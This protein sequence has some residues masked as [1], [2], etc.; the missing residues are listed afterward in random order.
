MFLLDRVLC[1][2]CWSDSDGCVVAVMVMLMVK[3]LIKVMMVVKSLNHVEGTFTTVA[4]AVDLDAATAAVCSRFPSL[5]PSRR[6]LSPSW[7]A[8]RCESPREMPKQHAKSQGL[9]P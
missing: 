5:F 9:K 1:S 3:F 8:R 4:I 6:P 7:H 2:C